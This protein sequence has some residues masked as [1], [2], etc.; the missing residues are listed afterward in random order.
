MWGEF[1]TYTSK[2]DHS[3]VLLRRVERSNKLGCLLVGITGDGVV[4]TERENKSVFPYLLEVVA[5]ARGSTRCNECFF[6]PFF[7]SLQT[8]SR[9][10]LSDGKQN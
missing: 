7:P 8:D 9:L 6:F 5:Q 3:K 10:G 4:Q 1:E 2:E